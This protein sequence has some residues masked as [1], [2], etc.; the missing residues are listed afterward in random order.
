MTIADDYQWFFRRL[1][2]MAALID[3]EGRFLEVNDALAGRLGRTREAMTGHKPAD[4]V[5]AASARRIE[6]EFLATLRRTG[7]LVNGRIDFLTGSGEVVECLTTSLV[8][9]L[10]DGSVIRT[11]AIFTEPA[12]AGM[13]LTDKEMKLLQRKNLL[14][15]LGR[16]DWKISGR[17]GAAELLGVRPT[18]LADR[19]RSFGLRK[20]GRR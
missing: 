3:G 13:I 2:V 11:V 12:E 8:E 5:T 6:S 14:T 18:T 20:P 1:P 15:A 9:R 17:G 7:K 16:S 19:I 4:F 10:A